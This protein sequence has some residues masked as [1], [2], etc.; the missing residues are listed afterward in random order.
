[1][2]D[3]YLQRL[4]KARDNKSVLKLRLINLQGQAGNK[5]ILVFEGD[6]DKIVYSRWLARL[7]FPMNY[8]VFVCNGKPMV[9]K[10]QDIIW[11]DMG[12]L[13]KRVMVFIDRD[14]DDDTG[15]ISQDNL[16][17]TDMYSVENYL[18][19]GAVIA[20]TLRDE[21]PCHE[22][23]NLI[24]Q[25]VS[26]FIIDYDKFLEENTEFNRR[27]FIYRKLG[28][29]PPYSL[30]TKIIDYAYVEVG[31]V[32][33]S[34]KDLD[35]IIP[36]ISAL[37]EEVN[38][39][40]NYEFAKI[41]KG[42]RFRGKNAYLF[43]AKWLNNLCETFERKSGLFCGIDIVGKPRKA[44]LTLGNFASKSPMPSGLNQFLNRFAA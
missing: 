12:E 31:Q 36:E 25:V 40:L 11:C 26:Q 41:N 16:F 28:Q 35:A 9:A 18:V 6:D 10:V 38:K 30:P 43:F 39:R 34:G 8:Q 21:F 33:S 5:I 3:N 13:A 44:E 32:R 1:M 29:V 15:F 42:E 7:N 24:Q 37:S 19:D 22:D 20:L 23:D 2:Q 14:F 4:R 27:L 17:T